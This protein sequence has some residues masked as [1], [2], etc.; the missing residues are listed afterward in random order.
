MWYVGIARY[1][2]QNVGAM[3]AVHDSAIGP[4]QVRDP[5]WAWLRRMIA[6]WLHS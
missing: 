6:T 5:P 2:G 1:V 4:E 3:L